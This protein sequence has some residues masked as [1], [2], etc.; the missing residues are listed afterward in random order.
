LKYKDVLANQSS[1]T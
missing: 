1:S